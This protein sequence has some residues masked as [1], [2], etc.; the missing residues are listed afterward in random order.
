MKLGE[1]VHNM[2]RSS[3]PV[4]QKQVIDKNRYACVLVRA[5]VCAITACNDSG[6]NGGRCSRCGVHKKT[7]LNVQ[8]NMH[9]SC[10]A[11]KVGLHINTMVVPRGWVGTMQTFISICF[12]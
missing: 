6:L 2:I 1:C 5:R 12:N 10:H 3:V 7:V 9:A 8:K 4:N 11:L